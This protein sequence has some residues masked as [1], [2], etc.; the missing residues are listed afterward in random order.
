MRA[1]AFAVSALLLA[2][3]TTPALA[4]AGGEACRSPQPSSVDPFR[5]YGPEMRF[6]VRRNGEAVGSHAVQF[7]RSGSDL[8]VR[9][10]FTIEISVLAI[11]VYTYLYTSTDVWRGGCLVALTAEVDDNGER[12]SVRASREADSLRVDGPR[13]S[14]LAPPD[15]FPTNHWHSGVLGSR[16]VLNTL[17]GT[18][19]TVTIADQGPITVPVN[20]DLRSVRHFVYSGD[21]RNDVWYDDRGRWV[22]MSFAGRDGSR[23]DVVCLRCANELAVS[24]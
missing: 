5:L 23:I 1:L 18:L 4:V 21:L 7:E 16:Q 20:G 8:L 14:R 9:N 19:D 12:V 22:G 10:R 2:A 24:Q 11:P 3:G 17:T 6:E 15:I 13:G